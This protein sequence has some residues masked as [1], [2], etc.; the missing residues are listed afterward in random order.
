MSEPTHRA[1]ASSASAEVLA[2][3]RRLSDN[4][5]AAGVQ[6]R[7]IGGVGVALRARSAIP[8]PLQR[9]YADLD[10]V[11]TSRHGPLLSTVLPTL[12]YE[13]SRR[14][15][16]LHGRRRM[17]FADQVQG[18]RLDVFI[19][20]FSMCHALSFEGR[21]PPGHPSAYPSDLLLTKLQIVEIN[22]KDLRDVILL[23]IDHD[24]DTFAEASGVS[25]DR[26]SE[27]TS[28]DWGWYTTV[29]DNLGKLRQYASQ[30]GDLTTY[31]ELV[32]D[33]I[34]R[35]ISRIES[36]PKSLRWRARARLGRRA[37][38]YEEPDQVG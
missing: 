8:E 4:L 34:D 28:Q 12:G 1:S 11:V 13:P 17:L 9:D 37:I 35:L 23:L 10:I 20:D 21:L 30:T 31:R 36:N 19:G 16:A 29:H 15:N 7:F 25:A 14:F 33:H 38:W 22:L 2:Q 5:T 26:V 18:R 3:A 6:A 24:F 27:V 32:L